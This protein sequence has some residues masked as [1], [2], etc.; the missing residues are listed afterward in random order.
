M[1]TISYESVMTS[2]KHDYYC[3]YQNYL[4]SKGVMHKKYDSIE[5]FLLDWGDADMNFN[6]LF[7]WDIE[8]DE[9]GVITFSAFFMQQRKGNYFST[10]TVVTKS[11]EQKIKEYLVPR[12]EH[13][14]KLW[15]PV[16]NTEPV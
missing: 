7:R 16:S 4:D 13:L 2:S 14:C 6:L 12:W 1:D 15:S 11:D 10:E 3:E 8:E 5:G 9:K